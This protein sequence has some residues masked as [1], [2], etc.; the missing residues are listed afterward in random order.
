MFWNF[1]S[2]LDYFIERKQFPVYS[3]NTDKPS[4]AVFLVLVALILTSLHHHISILKESLILSF[5]FLCLKKRVWFYCENQFVSRVFQLILV[6]SLI[7]FVCVWVGVCVYKRQG[8]PL[9]F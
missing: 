5:D 8:S 2:V 9:G 6:K 4:F 1:F 3:L 7:V